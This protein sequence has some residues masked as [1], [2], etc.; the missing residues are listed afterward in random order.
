MPRETA[1]TGVNPAP[2]FDGRRESVINDQSGS[3]QMGVRG[4]F[5]NTKN[6]HYVN[7]LKDKEED[8]T[9]KG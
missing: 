5:E 6:A 1:N 7:K 9:Q 4:D 2:H 3:A 8:N